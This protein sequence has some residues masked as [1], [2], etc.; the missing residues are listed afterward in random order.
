MAETAANLLENLI[1]EIPVRQWVI[2]FPKRIRHYLQTDVILQAVLPNRRN[3][4]R[5]FVYDAGDPD[6][7][8]LPIDA[9]FA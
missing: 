6:F 7:N 1:P 5:A 8:F 9:C 3:A 4:A 2:S